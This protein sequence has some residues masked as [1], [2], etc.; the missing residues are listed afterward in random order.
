MNRENELVHSF[1][2]I[3]IQTLQ[4]SPAAISRLPATNS[5]VVRSARSRRA[6]RMC[7]AMHPEQR[8]RDRRQRA[9]DPL[10]IPRCVWR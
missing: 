9:D 2:L 3:G 1:L 5:H 10:R 6:R 7:P 8:R 4:I